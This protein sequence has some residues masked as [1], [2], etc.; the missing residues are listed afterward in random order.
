[1]GCSS[2]V[3]QDFAVRNYDFSPEIYDHRLVLIQ[4]K[5]CFASVGHSLHVLGRHEGVNEK[6]LSVSF[7]FVNNDQTAKGL[8]ASMIIRI[9]L[10]TCKNTGEAI[11]LLKQLPHS[12]S[13]NFSIGDREGKTAIVEISPFEFE[14]REGINTLMCTN[15]FQHQDMLDKNRNDHINSHKRITHMNNKN[16]DSLSGSE[17]FKWFKD[18]SSGMFYKDYNGLFGTL[19]TFA[20][21]FR[22][23]I[24]LT[25]LPYGDTFNL[26]WKS[27]V[28][29]KDV[30]Q[31]SLRGSLEQESR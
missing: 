11:E 4:P 6:G 24:V 25:S 30:K 28:E 29:G 13:Y 10:D 17:V 15:H 5:D 21:L 18:P 20:Y 16:L 3:N 31:R 14:I 9:V 8:T 1:M 19:H 27:W 2:V 22:S 23:N 12:W 7:H 26:D